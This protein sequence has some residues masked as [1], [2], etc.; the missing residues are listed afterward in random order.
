MAEIKRKRMTATRA[1]A[2][3]GTGFDWSAFDV[4]SVPTPCYVCDE[5]A[6]L[7]NLDVLKGIQTNTGCKI[8]LAL[9]AFAMF[10]TFPLLHRCLKGAAASSLFEARLAAEEFGGEVH[11]CSP[12]YRDDE[13]DQ[14]A[15]LATHMTFNSFSQKNLFQPR[16][17][18][19]APEVKCAM[20]INPQH[21]E[22]RVPLY[23]PCAQY[24]R[25][26]VTADQLKEHGLDNISGL[27]FHTL[28]ELG[29]DALQRTV[30]AVEASFA[31]HLEQVTWI[32]VGGGHQLTRQ[33]YN[34]DLLCS[35]LARIRE[36][37]DVEIYLE[38]GDAV[39]SDAGV[40][41]TSVLDM[42][43]NEIDIAILDASAATH[44]PDVL[45]MPYRPR[46]LNAEAPGVLPHTYRLAGPSCLAGDVIGDYSFAEPLTTGS[47][48]VLLDMA[49][50]TMVK[51]TSFNGLRL[52]SIAILREDGDTHVVRNFTYEDYRSRL[53]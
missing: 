20:R 5:R 28:C 34:I 42:V 46:I 30:E 9:K 25:L 49:Q 7:Q 29:A 26:G 31:P 40:L 39:V 53:S 10:S 1:E 35:V 41:A 22:V 38:P 23:D 15:S 19:I 3:V 16:V 12:A 4:T 44:M 47:R 17:A 36:E 45:E 6:L 37:Y 18:R 14:L 2:A 51:N 27:H 11:V 24:S 21:S 43:H 50:Y 52:P 33:H 13:F 32:N 48:L 8:I